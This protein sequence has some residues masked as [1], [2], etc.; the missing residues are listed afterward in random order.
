MI[1]MLREIGSKIL[2]I[3][4]RITIIIAPLILIVGL[5]FWGCYTSNPFISKWRTLYIETAMGTMTHQWLATSLLPY[6]VVNPV[7]Y[8]IKQS[9]VDNILE[10]N[11]SAIPDSGDSTFDLVIEEHYKD[12]D[13]AKYSFYKLFHEVDA[14][15]LPLDF[16][17]EKAQLSN[18]LDLGIKTKQGDGVWAIDL[19]NKVLII[20]VEGE[21][22]VGKLA[23]IKDSEQVYLETSSRNGAG[24]TVTSMCKEHDAIIGVNAGGFEDIDGKGNGGIAVGKIISKGQFIDNGNSYSVYQY[25]GFDI[26]NNFIVGKEIDIKNFRDAVQ[27]SPILIANGEK[28]VGNSYGMGIQPRTAIGQNIYK[29]TMLLV[30]DGRQ[31]GYSLGATVSDCADILIRYNAWSAMNMDGGSSSSMTYNGEMITRTSSPAKQGRYVPNAWLVRKA[32]E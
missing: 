32:C 2:P 17:Y 29:E 19:I 10:E 3:I 31:I 18:I 16:D 6:D 25:A 15:T 13:S 9:T 21:G 11:S 8:N 22:Y 4:K 1:S 7:I 28:K 14:S 23:I 5:Y 26:D 20:Q 24:Q 27:F 12:D 30:I